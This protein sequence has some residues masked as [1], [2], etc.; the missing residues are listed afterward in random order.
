MTLVGHDVGGQIV[1]SYLHRYPET[2]RRAVI[3]NVAVPGVEPWS[4]VVRNPYIWH[5]AFHSIPD[6]PE[7]LVAGKQ[8]DYLGFF[9]SVIT[10]G[11]DAV[12]EA[13]RQRFVAAY[14]WPEALHVGFEWYRAFA[15]DERDNLSSRGQV[16]STPLLY[17]VRR[18]R[19][20]SRLTYAAFA[21][22]G[23]LMLKDGSSPAWDTGSTK[24]RRAC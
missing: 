23:S 3:M 14:T 2:L 12:P 24:T 17:L 6:L 21:R 5:F 15:Q 1:Y 7:R 16:V 13:Q 8:D 9:Y 19:A 11:A 22:V 20:S 10:A 18:S 4:E